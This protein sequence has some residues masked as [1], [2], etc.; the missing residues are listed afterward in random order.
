MFSH[1]VDYESGQH[2]VVRHAERSGLIQSLEN[3]RLW[4]CL[5]DVFYSQINDYKKDRASLHLEVHSERTIGS[6][7]S[8]VNKKSNLMLEK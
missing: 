7:H 2:N 3:K 1:Q 4:E 6:R 5:T 8:Y